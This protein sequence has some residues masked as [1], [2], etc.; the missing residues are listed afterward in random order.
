MKPGPAT[1]TAAT[2]VDLA[3]FGR[4]RLGQRA[5]VGP[6]GLGQHHRGVG[7]QIAVAR[8]ARRLDRHGAAVEPGRQR[9]GGDQ[10][11]ERGIEMRGEAGIERHDAR[12]LSASRCAATRSTV[13]DRRS[14]TRWIRSPS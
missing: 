5:R 7:R 14:V 6:G 12:A 2:L 1:A 3:Q 11:V 13:G 9:A 4:E 8:V 10:R